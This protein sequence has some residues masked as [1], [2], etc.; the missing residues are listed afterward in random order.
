M[1]VEMEL[2]LN[3]EV[4]LVMRSNRQANVSHLPCGELSLIITQFLKCRDPVL[5]QVSHEAFALLP[6]FL[7]WG[8][9]SLYRDIN[10]WRHFFSVCVTISRCYDAG[11]ADTQ[12]EKHRVGT[13]EPHVSHRAAASHQI[14]P[15][16]IDELSEDQEA[17]ER[18]ILRPWV[19]Y[20]DLTF[21][22]DPCWGTALGF[23]YTLPYLPLYLYFGWHPENHTRK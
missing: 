17:N 3:K 10:F 12:W 20:V 11:N 8:N 15:A 6:R 9:L 13:I 18:C 19:L 2:F 22:V 21:H 7:K 16:V 5:V 4:E 1:E 23:Y 14:I